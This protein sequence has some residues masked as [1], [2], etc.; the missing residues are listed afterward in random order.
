MIR[1]TNQRR[2][3][4]A[5]NPELKEKKKNK[6]NTSQVTKVAL[7]NCNRSTHLYTARFPVSFIVQKLTAIKAD[8]FFFSPNLFLFPFP[9]F[10]TGS[11]FLLSL[12][13]LLL[14]ILLPL[15][16]AVLLWPCVFSQ[17]YPRLMMCHLAGGFGA[18]HVGRAPATSAARSQ[19]VPSFFFL[20]GLVSATCNTR[21]VF[22]SFLR[23]VLFLY[24]PSSLIENIF[25]LNSFFVCYQQ[26]IKKV[27][28]GGCKKFRD[29]CSD[30][31]FLLKHQR[32]KYKKKKR[33]GEKSLE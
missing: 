14:L 16:S 7:A 22:F 13:L 33:N 3:S 25:C 1:A 21:Y 6:L 19:N 29:C 11:C 5:A 15:L 2:T 8:S 28:A 9:F 24:P 12:L 10:P 20:L 23:Q 17:S 26:Q 30:E 4:I 18:T 32:A 31:D 27:A